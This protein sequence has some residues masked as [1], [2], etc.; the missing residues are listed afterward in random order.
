VRRITGTPVLVREF[1]YFPAAAELPSLDVSVERSI[2]F[3][4]CLKLSRYFVADR[5]KE[6][7]F[8]KRVRY[9]VGLTGLAPIA[10]GGLMLPATAH[11]AT[12]DQTPRASVKTVRLPVATPDTGCTGHTPAGNESPGGFVSELFYYNNSG[13]IGDVIETLF[14]ITSSPIFSMNIYHDHNRVGHQTYQHQVG[15]GYRSHTFYVHKRFSTPVQV[16]V[17]AISSHGVEYGATCKSVA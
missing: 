3:S 9:L 8:M 7:S 4:R 6:A 10:A 13:C 14:V 11:A 16:C 1:P 17:K 5:R 15:S 2:A 12:T